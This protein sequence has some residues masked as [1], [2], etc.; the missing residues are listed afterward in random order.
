[1]CCRNR[2][3]FQLELSRPQNCCDK[4]EAILAAKVF[5]CTIFLIYADDIKIYS[6]I[7]GL[8]DAL[9]LQNDLVSLV[10]WSGVNGLLCNAN[11]CKIVSFSRR[12][13]ITEFAYSLN[14]IV[15][16]RSNSI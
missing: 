5:Q 16:P 10:T 9:A 7:S 12:S 11:K 13:L 15:L 4:V 14:G 6:I 3:H 2:I 1:M 8:S